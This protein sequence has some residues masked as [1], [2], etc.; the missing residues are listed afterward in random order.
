MLT[1]QSI[2][3]EVDDLE[4]SPFA[5]VAASEHV[6]HR[7]TV[8]KSAAWSLPVI[9]AAV[10]VP[11]AAASQVERLPLTCTRLTSKGQPM[12]QVAYADG[13]TQTYNNGEVNSD[14]TLQALCRDKGPLS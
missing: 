4:P 3:P 8:V 10:A 11:L 13:S 9:M 12:Y 1:E 7:R 2:P 14:K 5:P 6:V